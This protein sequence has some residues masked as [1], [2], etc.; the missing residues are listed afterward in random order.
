MSIRK[1][2]AAVAGAAVLAISSAPSFAAESG[3]CDSFPWP[4]NTELEW[5]KSSDSEALKSGAKLAAPPAKAVELSLEPMS[6]VTFPVP[7][8][9]RLKPEGEVYGGV[10]SFDN[11]G[12][13]AGSYQVALQ[14]PGWIDV[15]QDGKALKSTAH[16]GKTDCDGVRKTVRFDLGPGPFSVQF[17]NIRKDNIKFSVRK[18]E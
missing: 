3:G 14:T 4:I 11:P 17:S 10:V 18:A 16:S 6:A 5:M 13:A 12:G 8:T 7:P 15:A 9:G 1:S 2:L